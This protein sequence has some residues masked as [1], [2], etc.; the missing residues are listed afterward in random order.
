MRGQELLGNGIR[1]SL[2]SLGSEFDMLAVQQPPSAAAAR[3]APRAASVEVANCRQHGGVSPYQRDSACPSRASSSRP[4]PPRDA[5]LDSRQMGHSPDGDG[6]QVQPGPY[7]TAVMAQAGI[8]QQQQLDPLAAAAP[9]HLGQLD[10]HQQGH[11]LRQAGCHQQQQ[12]QLGELANKSGNYLTTAAA[13]V[14]GSD[15]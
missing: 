4:P 7:L 14:R 6:P 10:Y 9:R 15:V 2:A 5:Y 8:C 13:S 11:Q 1:C 3:A 12:Q